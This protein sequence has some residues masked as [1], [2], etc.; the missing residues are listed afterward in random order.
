MCNTNGF[1]KPYPILFFLLLS[2]NG[3]SSDLILNSKTTNTDKKKIHHSHANIVIAEST[4][5]LNQ[6][7][8]CSICVQLSLGNNFF[9]GSSIN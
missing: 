7:C 1:I 3:T 5:N 8:L 9:L 2:L 6:L 4:E